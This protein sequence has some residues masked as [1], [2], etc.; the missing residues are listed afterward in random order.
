MKTNLIAAVVVG[1]LTFSLSGFAL[2]Q[3]NTPS[4]AELGRKVIQANRMLD[5]TPYREKMT[6]EKA[7]T[8]DEEWRP[9]SYQET[10]EI[11]PDKRHNKQH[12][13]NRFESVTIGQTIY[14]RQGEGLW[15]VRTKLDPVLPIATVVDISKPDVQISKP[16]IEPSSEKVAV[17]ESTTKVSKMLLSNGSVGEW[18]DTTK[19]WFDQKGRL[20]KIESVAYVPPQKGFIRT[21]RIFEYDPNIKIEAP[22]Q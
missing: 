5:S 16:T 17:F 9:Y 4:P 2:S 22:I 14:S 11:R 19:Y 20:L 13:G 6:V 10:E 18:T 8:L 1:F 15:S 7:K 3:D 12:T 21:T